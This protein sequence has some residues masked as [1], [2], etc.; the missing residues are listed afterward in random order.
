MRRESGH[1]STEQLIALAAARADDRGRVRI[2]ELAAQPLHVDVHDVGKRVV[3]LVPDVLGDVGAADHVAGA[4]GE[5]FEQRVFAA[6]QRDLASVRTDA[7]AGDV[8]R[9]R[10][11]LRGARASADGDRA[12]SAR[13][14][15]R[16][17]RGSRTA[18]S[19]SRRPRRRVPPPGLDRV[20]RRQHQ[21][22]DVR[23]RGAQLTAHRQPVAPGSIT[24]S[25]IAS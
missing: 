3:V 13:A 10:R 22:R 7:R 21:H 9:E 20:A 15:G 25:T 4:P 1:G 12:A 14:A 24:S 2:V 17:A 19:G 18:W 5:V 23:S 16:A 11:R 6:G 8:D